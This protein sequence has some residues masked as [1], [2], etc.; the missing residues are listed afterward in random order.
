MKPKTFTITLSFAM[1]TCFAFAQKTKPSFGVTAGVTVATY[2]P[3]GF[4]RMVMKLQIQ[5]PVLRQEL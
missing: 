1:L 2:F 3:K 5:K 4:G